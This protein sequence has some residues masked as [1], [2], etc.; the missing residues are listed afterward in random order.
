MKESTLNVPTHLV[1]KRSLN[2][3]GGFLRQFKL[4]EIPQF[5]NVLKGDM[6]IVGPRPC[7]P[8]QEDIIIER[9]YRNVFSIR[10]GITGISQINGIDMSTP[11][12]LAETDKLYIIDYGLKIYFKILLFT[13]FGSGFG[14]RITRN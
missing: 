13:F 2:K 1:S 12:P 10:P 7:L 6:S 5:V 9:S 3:I 8:I 4:D 14:D 11:I